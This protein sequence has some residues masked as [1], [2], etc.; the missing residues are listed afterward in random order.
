MPRGG[1]ASSSVAF[2]LRTRRDSILLHFDKINR[3]HRM[4]KEKDCFFDSPILQILF[5]LSI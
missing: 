3:M 4:V 1:S 5:I 2:A